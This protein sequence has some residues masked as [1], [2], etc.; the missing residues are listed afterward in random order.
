MRRQLAWTATAV[1]MLVEG[2]LGGRIGAAPPTTPPPPPPF[3][4]HVRIDSG[5]LQGAVA[6][7]VLSFKGV[8][9][10]APPVGDL[11][12]RAPQPVK[13]W[14]GV[15]QATTYGHDCMQQPFPSDAAPLGTEPA[16]DCLVLNVWRPAEQSAGKLPVMVWIYGGGF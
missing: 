2:M 14:T 8:P 3:A 5:E 1:L 6:D 9:F 15:R 7:G 16:E 12:W 10:A 4:D 11:R 13:A